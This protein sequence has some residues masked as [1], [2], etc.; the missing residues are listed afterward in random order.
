MQ[1]TSASHAFGWQREDAKA[2]DFV[3]LL[4]KYALLR[5]QSPLC[6]LQWLYSR[7]FNVLLTPETSELPTRPPVS[8]VQS[9]EGQCL[10][11]PS[12]SEIMKIAA[13]SNVT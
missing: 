3:C 6:F 9:Q 13:G 7:I 8:A 2:F 11:R 12:C 10:N 5:P 1:E 4:M